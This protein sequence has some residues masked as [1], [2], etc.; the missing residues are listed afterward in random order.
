MTN[1]EKCECCGTTDFKYDEEITVALIATNGVTYKKVCYDCAEKMRQEDPRYLFKTPRNLDPN[2]QEWM[3][4]RENILQEQFEQSK[5]DFLNKHQEC[6]LTKKVIGTRY[7]E[8]IVNVIDPCYGSD[9]TLG[10]QL[11]IAA[12]EYSCIKWD[13][14]YS[15][16]FDDEFFETAETDVF[17]IY[18]DGKIPAHDE[19]IKV[20]C[21]GAD[22]GLLG[23]FDVKK[24][25]NLA[26][27]LEEKHQSS[28]TIIRGV[29]IQDI[30]FVA[31]LG[32]ITTDVYV[33]IQNGKIVAVELRQWDYIPRD[34]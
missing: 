23:I 29:S 28:N 14:C 13:M 1:S 12:G 10:K 30:G 21:I 24:G 16:T 34:Q 7:Y 8:G 3:E 22:S 18:L 27:W 11:P 33:A 26:R 15:Y 17:G 31:C 9:T 25:L 4:N 32:D 2:I 20:G 6:T 5:R 19:M